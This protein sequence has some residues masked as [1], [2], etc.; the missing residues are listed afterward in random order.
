MED[1]VDNIIGSI[2]KPTQSKNYFWGAYKLVL[3]KFYKREES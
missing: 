3:I 2:H 1:I